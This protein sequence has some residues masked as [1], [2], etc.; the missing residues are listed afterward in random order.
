[1]LR[2]LLLAA[3]VSGAPVS[4]AV[5]HC[6]K[7]IDVEELEVLER[8]SILTSG[9]EIL[10]VETGFTYPPA[11]EE[12][13]DLRA[14]TCMPGWMD[15]HVHLASE[16]NPKAYEER[17]RLNEADYAFRAAAHAKSTL[18]AGFTTVRDLGTRAG[19]S[20]ALN[21]AIAQ[22]LTVGP[23]I[24]SAGRGARWPPPAATPIRPTA[25]API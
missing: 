9:D 1:M 2:T 13:I 24:Y 4:G 6:G 23:T 18:L 11:G 3:A 20:M 22:G 8:V 25:S 16:S 17:F 7:L 12:A 10:R 5:L 21:R 19:V 15:M 14:H